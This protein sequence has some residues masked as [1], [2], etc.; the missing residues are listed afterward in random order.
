GGQRRQQTAK[1]DGVGLRQQ[2]RVLGLFR[3]GGVRQEAAGHL[4]AVGEIGRG[5][6]DKRQ[7]RRHYPASCVSRESRGPRQQER[8]R[9]QPGED[10]AFRARQ[11]RQ[12][13]QR[14]EG[15]AANPGRARVRPA[16][17]QL[18]PAE[19]EQGQR[20]RAK[21]HGFHARSRRPDQMPGEDQSQAGDEGE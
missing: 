2:R 3:G 12:R 14:A 18:A 17:V 16:F 21:E 4:K 1:A 11:Q 10:D 8:Q 6:D 15:R 9:D 5:D 19:P 13:R 20:K 7:R